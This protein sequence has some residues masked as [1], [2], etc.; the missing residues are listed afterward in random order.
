MQSLL[1]LSEV[2]SHSLS[3]WYNA[4]CHALPAAPFPFALQHAL[5]RETQGDGHSEACR[6]SL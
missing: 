4:E 1:K 5:A 3:S 6:F 2:S